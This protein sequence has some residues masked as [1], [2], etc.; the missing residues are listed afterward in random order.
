MPHFW[1]SYVQDWPLLAHHALKYFS[2]AS[3]SSASE[4]NFSA[5]GFIHSKLRYCLGWDTVEKLDYVKTNNLLFMVNAN[6]DAYNN[7]CDNEDNARL[8]KAPKKTGM[9]FGFL[10]RSFVYSAVTHLDTTNTLNDSAP[11]GGR[12]RG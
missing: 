5:M 6:L 4:R 12:G 10:K 9:R 8:A 2:V 3:S 1:G 7:A 11:F